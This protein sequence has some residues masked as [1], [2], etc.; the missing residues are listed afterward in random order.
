M[1]TSGD[2]ET[3]A[4]SFPVPGQHSQTELIRSDLN[5]KQCTSHVR[6]VEGCTTSK[7]TPPLHAASSAWCLSPVVPW[8]T[9]RVVPP[10]SKCPT[11]ATAAAARSQASLERPRRHQH[12]P[13][14]VARPTGGIEG[15]PGA[16]DGQG[17]GVHFK[18]R[19]RASG[20]GSSAVST[21]Y[22]THYQ[23]AAGRSP[24]S[25]SCF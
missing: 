1:C 19:A 16:R 7:L 15:L 4:W 6:R 25:S 17:D 13:R 22:T 5:V 20:E 2:R 8:S 12:Q 9:R 14:P 10:P 24:V 23:P 3:A 21:S 11:G 18:R